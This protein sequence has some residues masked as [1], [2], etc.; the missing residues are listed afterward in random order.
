MNQ[1]T[2]LVLASK[3]VNMIIHKLIPWYI[4]SW[5][6]YV[7]WSMRCNQFDYKWSI[8]CLIRGKCLMKYVII[9]CT[10]VSV[11]SRRDEVNNWI[12][13]WWQSIAIKIKL[14]LILWQHFKFVYV[15]NKE[16]SHNVFTLNDIYDDY[17]THLLF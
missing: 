8:L 13:N 5:Y 11:Y 1:R 15:F 9:I 7:V 2:K 4:D 16:R 14:F 10:F 6:N 12:F 3:H 17:P